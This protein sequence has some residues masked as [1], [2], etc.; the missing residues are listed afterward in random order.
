MRQFRIRKLA[1]E[2]GNIRQDLLI[3]HR[4]LRDHR[5]YSPK[6]KILENGSCQSILAIEKS[7]TTEKY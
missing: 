7:K 3:S 5:E 2:I 4:K 1:V 6:E